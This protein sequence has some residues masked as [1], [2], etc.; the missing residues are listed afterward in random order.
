MNRS[1]IWRVAA[2]AVASVFSE[3]GLLWAAQPGIDSIDALSAQ[4][5]SDFARQDYDSAAEKYERLTK[6]QPHDANTL[7]NLGVTYHFLE[8]WQD[9]VETLRKAVRLSPNLQS[10][11]LI[12]GIDLV[13]V[14]SAAEAI[15]HLEVVLRG[16][17]DQRDALL[18][19]ASANMSLNRFEMAAE[20]YYRLTSISKDD[21]AGWYGLGLCFEHIAEAASRSLA[22]AGKDSGFMQRLIGEFLTEQ[23]SGFDAEEAFHRALRFDN[24]AQGVH[25]ALGFAYLRLEE[26]GR[27]REEFKS[28]QKL[29]SG[30]LLSKLGTAALS[31][32]LGD[33]P[34]SLQP[35]CEVYG[36][37][38]DY[39]DSQLDFFLASL[40]DQTQRS[41]L[42]FLASSS[43]PASCTPGLD[44]LRAELTS[45]EPAVRLAHAFEPLRV[46]ARGPVP[47]ATTTFSAARASFNAGRY[48]SCAEELQTLG[49]T[50]PETNLLLA[51]C[52]YLSGR[53]YAAY[54]TVN[55]ASLRGPLDS[56]ALFWKAESTRRVAQAA[57]QRSIALEPDS[58]RAHILLGDIFSQRKQWDSAVS[59]YQ[60]AVRLQPKGAALYLGLGTVFWKTGQ[61]E[62]AETALKQALSQDPDNVTANFILGDLYVRLHRLEEAVP[63]LQ[64]QLAHEPAPLAAHAGLGKAYAAAGKTDEAIAELRLALPMDRFGDIHF[65]LYKLYKNQGK[66]ELAQAALA[67]SKKL[68]AQE[69]ASHQQRTQRAGEVMKENLTPD[70]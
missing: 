47:Q 23:G 58:W 38:K 63:Y 5:Q 34:S 16:Q 45:P 61:N 49:S 4:A 67:E 19:L 10:A 65:Q 20:I 59:H 28:E 37:D 41:I 55:T 53:F 18:A 9:A 12:L 30:N 48:G 24:A 46:R 3:G 15:P 36:T 27:A 25:A 57:L 26:F 43:V 64:K 42:T 54:Q 1:R 39:F 29:H 2:L 14:G 35:L 66:E 7:N 62:D 17:P 40:R 13:R 31:M 6:L 68:R 11:N 51:Q 52:A 56:E 60:A 69:L 33:V 70:K 32:E 50:Q 21:S 8:R 22:A 44:L